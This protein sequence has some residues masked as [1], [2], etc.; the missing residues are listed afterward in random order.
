MSIDLPN[1]THQNKPVISKTKNII[2]SFCG[3]VSEWYEFVVY[4]FCAPFLAP[5]FFPA[6]NQFVSILAVYGAFAAGFLMRPLGA[7]VFGYFGD[8]YG[9]QKT[10]SIA[11][12]LIGLP[13]VVMG[14]MPTYHQIGIIAPIILILVRML[15]GLSV[16][17]QFTG[18]AVFINEHIGIQRRYFG[19]GITF[20]GAFFGM[21]L[22]AAVGALLTSFLNDQQLANWGWRIPFILGIFVAIL[23]YYLKKHTSETP[24]FEKLKLHNALAKNPILETFKTQKLGMLLGFFICWLTPLIVYQLFIFMPTYAHHY[25]HIDLHYALEINAVGMMILAVFTIIWGYVA[26]YTGFYKVMSIAAILLII[27]SPLLYFL[28]HSMPQ[29]FFIVQILFA[30]LGAGFIG[31]VM[32]MLSH[33][34]TINTRYSALSI[35]YNLGF[36]I[37]GG[38]AALFSMYLIE[39]TAVIWSPGIYLSLAAIISLI[40]LTIARGHMKA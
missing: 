11:V 1:N 22:A 31:P 10:V 38:S 15:Q 7:I 8:K 40:A 16:G 9:R 33:L 4:A 14:I 25:L 34:F 17:G 12:I 30:I 32:G 24:Q 39:K 13:T 3:S 28:M 5:L 21:L 19:A 20:A 35:S 37:F 26:D 6:E 23:G 2:A 29:S 18:S 36:G 27:A